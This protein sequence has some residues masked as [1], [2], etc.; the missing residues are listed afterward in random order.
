[1]ITKEKEEEEEEGE[2]EISN[3]I[4]VLQPRHSTFATR[5]RNRVGRHLRYARHRARFRDLVAS[6]TRSL[7]ARYPYASDDRYDLRSAREAHTRQP[8]RT[9]SLAVGSKNFRICPRA[10]TS[11]AG[12]SPGRLSM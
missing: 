9:L 11:V 1:M 3:I 5:G 12:L 8:D 2:R 6:F 4:R 7:T 10:G